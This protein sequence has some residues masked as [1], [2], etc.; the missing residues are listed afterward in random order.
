MHKTRYLQT[1]QQLATKKQENYGSNIV[2]FTGGLGLTHQIA[3]PPSHSFT[4]LPPFSPTPSTPLRKGAL[5]L[6]GREADGQ[7][8]AVALL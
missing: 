5:M 3:Q 8:T 7:R 4:D 6:S 2:V 1:P